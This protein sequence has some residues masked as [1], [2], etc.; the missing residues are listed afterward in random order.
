MQLMDREIT[1]VFLLEKNSASVTVIWDAF[2]ACICG[3]LIKFKALWDKNRELVKEEP[4][5]TISDKYKQ[6]KFIRIRIKTD[7]NI[8]SAIEPI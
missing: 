7:T 2:K 1:E 4:L 3:I 8:I 6:A 5:V